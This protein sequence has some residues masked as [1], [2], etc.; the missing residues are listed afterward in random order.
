[1]RRRF[2]DL[3]GAL[4]P[5]AKVLELGSGPGH[6]AVSVLESCPNLESY[7]LLD[8]SEHML[9]L[10]RERLT[11]F[12][13][14]R[15]VKADFKTA[16]W[17]HELSPP[18]AAVLAMQA[19]HEIRHKRHVPGL[20]GQIRELLEPDGLLAVCDGTPRDTAVL[21]QVSLCMTVDEQ[22]DAFA[23]AGFTETRLEDEIGAMIFVTGRASGLRGRPNI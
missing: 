15:F 4:P 12:E 11:R 7:T 22:L 20:Y 2:A 13:A 16:D 6:L 19:V 3:V 8:F 17:Y 18:Y 23:S 9:E 5:G 21:W 10:S 1:M 14:A